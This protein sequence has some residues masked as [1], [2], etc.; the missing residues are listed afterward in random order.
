MHKVCS[1]IILSNTC[2]GIRMTIRR[3]MNLKM[4][5]VRVLMNNNTV[6]AALDCCS[7]PE[8][9]RDVF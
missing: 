7:Y 4:Q 3:N 8:N 2:N 6:M 1:K 9:V 5:S